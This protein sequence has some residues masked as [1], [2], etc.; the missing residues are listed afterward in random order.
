MSTVAALG[1]LRDPLLRARELL[2]RSTPEDVRYAALELR[3][4]LEAM[5]YEKLRSFAEY[6]P[7]SFLERTW[8]PPQLLK[9]MK[10]LDPIADQSVTL[11]MG[12]PV[13]AG[14]IPKDE[15]FQ[16][17]GEHRA[18]GQAWLRKQYNKLGALLH[19]QPSGPD[20]TGPEQRDSLIAIANEIEKAQGGAIL[21]LWCG[22]TVRFQCDF[23]GE[24]PAVSEHFAREQRSA[25]CTNPTCEAE[26]RTETKGEEVFLIP[27]AVYPE[28]KGCGALIPVQNRDLKQGLVVR[29]S[30]CNLEHGFRCRWEY[31]A[32]NEI[33][34]PEPPSDI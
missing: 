1:A 6:L 12:P 13:V 26:Y 32:F 21:G 9:A 27:L 8:Q 11:H 31:G 24:E 19:L 28:C 25:I 18:F 22:R 33:S 20:T 4:C 7:P 3:L 29:C 17:I 16:L 30:K 15:Q 10:Q 23:C 5:T 14:V 2:A 34:S